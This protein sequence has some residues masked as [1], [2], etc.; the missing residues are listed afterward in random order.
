MWSLATLWTRL[1]T[2]YLLHLSF[3]LPDHNKSLFAVCA[4]FFGNR[5]TR[6]VSASNCD[7]PLWHGCLFRIPHSSSSTFEHLYQIETGDQV[8]NPEAVPRFYHILCQRNDRFLFK[9]YSIALEFRR[10]SDREEILWF[11]TS[12]FLKSCS[13]FGIVLD[14]W[15]FFNRKKLSKIAKDEQNPKSW[16]KSQ[17]PSKIP[18]AEQNPKSLAKSQK[19]NENPKNWTQF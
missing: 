14:I 15:D 11:W 12:E 13:V 16:A 5:T 1:L 3:Q 7:P 8:H 10:I 4:N 9:G 17:K 2:M 19:L 6:M 18:K